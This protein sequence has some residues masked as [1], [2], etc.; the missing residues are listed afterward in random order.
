M[1][2]KSW[3]RMLAGSTQSPRTSD[4][5]LGWELFGN[6]AIRQREWKISWLYQPL[7]TEDWQLFNLAEDPGEQY[8]LSAKF[9]M[10]KEALV[11]LWDEYVKTNGVIIGERSPFEGARKALRDPVPEFDSYPP[12]RGL[13]ALPYEKLIEMM[14]GNTEEK[15]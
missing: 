3:V 14:S 5:W 15:Q 6:R 1:Q 9:P 4:D 13:E 11:A 8:D 2:G 12:F 10:K 7:G